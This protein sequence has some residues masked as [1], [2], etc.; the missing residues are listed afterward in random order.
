M[1]NLIKFILYSFVGAAVS[2]ILLLVSQGI[3]AIVTCIIAAGAAALF[4]Y[5]LS[6]QTGMQKLLSIVSFIIVFLLY[7]ALYGYTNEEANS[8]VLA[9]LVFGV[10]YIF[11][12][13]V[14][15]EGS[16]EQ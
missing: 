10:P 1:K 16:N 8:N 2:F 5:Y 15:I 13:Y 4:V 11:A 6:Q 14:L 3:H 12:A 9:I 7:F